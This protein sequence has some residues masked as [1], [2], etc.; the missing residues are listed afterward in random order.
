MVP[1]PEPE[2]PSMV[3]TGTVLM[4]SSS[5]CSPV[6]HQGRRGRQCKAPLHPTPNWAATETATRALS[7]R[8]EE[9]TSEHQSLMRISYA[10]FCQKKKK[11]KMH[12]LTVLAQCTKNLA[13]LDYEHPHLDHLNH[14]HTHDNTKHVTTP[15]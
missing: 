4:H 3:S 7:R 11:V 8:S 6:P 14:I 2:G 1:L 13:T 5:L 10:A 9:H 12:L 15:K